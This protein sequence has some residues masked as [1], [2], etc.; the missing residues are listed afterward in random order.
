MGGR[1]VGDAAPPLLFQQTPAS[2]LMFL[3][4]KYMTLF[5]L[6]AKYMSNTNTWYFPSIRYLTVI[7]YHGKIHLREGRVSLDLW[8][9]MDKVHSGKGTMD[10]SSQNKKLRP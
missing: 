9:Q 10:P 4:L 7:K 1:G 5:S 3:L 2:T 6:I 8:F